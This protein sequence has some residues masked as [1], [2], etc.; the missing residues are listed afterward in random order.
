MSKELR[1]KRMLEGKRGTMARAQKG[2]TA[3][4]IL[5]TT[6]SWALPEYRVCG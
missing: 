1:A 2:V 4:Y 5:G 3:W 6:S